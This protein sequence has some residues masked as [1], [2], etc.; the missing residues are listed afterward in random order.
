VLHQIVQTISPRTDP[1]WR[2]VAGGYAEKSMRNILRQLADFFRFGRHWHKASG[3]PWNTAGTIIQYVHHRLEQSGETPTY[4]RSWKAASGAGT[5]SKLPSYLHM[6]GLY[7]EKSL[8][9]LKM[10]R[11]GLHLAFPGGQVQHRPAMSFPEVERAIDATRRTTKATFASAALALGLFCMLRAGEMSSLALHNAAVK[12]DS[13]S[14][15]IV[16]TFLDKTHIEDFRVAAFPRRQRWAAEYDLLA[17]TITSAQAT[18]TSTNEQPIKLFGPQI[19]SMVKSELLPLGYQLGSVR[20]SG[21]M[22][23]LGNRTEASVIVKMAGWSPK[24]ATHIRSYL[25]MDHAAALHDWDSARDQANKI[26][27]L[28]NQK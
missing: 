27:Q 19:I 20:P 4:A 3:S 23:H 2:A 24:A 12:H 11:Q 16:L 5:L 8:P 1:L 25:R 21:L 28:G 6:L 22:L 7:S 17:S 10:L 26:L 14:P 9:R 13:D 15:R 18:H